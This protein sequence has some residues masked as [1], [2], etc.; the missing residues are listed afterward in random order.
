MEND[1]LRRM[2]N[3]TESR[4]YITRGGVEK[5]M[6]TYTKCAVCAGVGKVKIGNRYIRCHHCNGRDIIQSPKVVGYPHA[7]P[8]KKKTVTREEI[9]RDWR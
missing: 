4:I 2:Q 8:V 3:R 5:T 6:T 7:L 1:I 9:E